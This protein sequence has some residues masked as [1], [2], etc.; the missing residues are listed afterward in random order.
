LRGVIR[1]WPRD[2]GT[3]TRIND[4]KNKSDE[5]KTDG[6]RVDIPELVA[7]LSHVH[8]PGGKKQGIGSEIK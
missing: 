1:N 8:S 6:T 3:P 7:N 2:F 4:P 5:L